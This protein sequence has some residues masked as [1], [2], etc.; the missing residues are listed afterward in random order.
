[1][2]GNVPGAIFG[3]VIGLNAAC[4]PD[5]GDG[6]ALLTDSVF[7]VSDVW[8]NGIE[9]KN[10][11]IDGATGADGLVEAEAAGILEDIIP[12][13]EDA[14]TP[15]GKDT[16]AGKDTPVGEDTPA[17]KDTPP[18][19]KDAPLD[20]AKPADT[21]FGPD[22]FDALSVS[23]AANAA[24]T[25]ADAPGA[26][27]LASPLDLKSPADS[28][29]PADLPA[30]APVALPGDS[31]V[32]ESAADLPA[33]LQIVFTTDGNVFD[34]AAPVFLGT[35]FCTNEFENTCLQLNPD[36]A[37]TCLYINGFQIKDE[38]SPVTLDAF[39]SHK[40]DPISMTVSGN[41]ALPDTVMGGKLVCSPDPDIFEEG[42]FGAWNC[43][44]FGELKAAI[45]G[46]I[47]DGA[48]VMTFPESSAVGF[49]EC[50]YSY[51]SPCAADDVNQ[52]VEPPAL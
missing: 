7:S 33:D 24:D 43:Y 49:E 5:P 31:S 11:A 25:A 18:V 32:V 41:N 1:M 45:I 52:C 9:S 51:H 40:N 26:D 8:D 42:I 19:G 23:D 16:P 34:A 38:D 35:A 37:S 2:A 10:V 3:G 44:K 30:D 50:D 28:Q 29:A 47:Y 46:T 13:G 22:T 48:I 15:V 17:A 36:F 6:P 20:I 4:Y 27:D 39:L 21:V 12:T 14:N